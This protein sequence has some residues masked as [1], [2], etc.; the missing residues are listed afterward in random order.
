MPNSPVLG[1]ASVPNVS[2]T[3]GSRPLP[4]WLQHSCCYPEGLIPM[5]CF[6][7]THDWLGSHQLLLSNCPILTLLYLLHL[8]IPDATSK[9]RTSTGHLWLLLPRAPPSST[10]HPWP[11]RSPQSTHSGPEGAGPTHLATDNSQPLF[12]K[13]PLGWTRT[14]KN[15][16]ISPL[17]SGSPL[18]YQTPS[19]T[20]VWGIL[21]RLLPFSSCHQLIELGQKL[22]LLQGACWILSVVM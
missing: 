11:G 1:P 14:T 12:Q 4:V 3:A 15:N 10:S 21:P 8:P 9:V 19:E 2:A 17:E 20:R 5:L 13:Q 16:H 22:F 6:K 7:Y 18:I